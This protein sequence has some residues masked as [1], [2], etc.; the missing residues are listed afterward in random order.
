[1]GELAA[2]LGVTPVP[3]GGW[4]RRAVLVAPGVRARAEDVERIR[5]VAGAEVRANGLLAVEVAVPGDLVVEVLG[6]PEGIR[7]EAGGAGWVDHPRTWENPGFVVRYA[8]ARAAAVARWAAALGVPVAT[9]EGSEGFQGELLDRAV[10]RR[11]LR[12]LA[13]VFSRREKGEVGPAYLER[14]AGVYHDA[15][16]GAAA[17]PRGDEAVSGVHVARVR[18]AAAVRWVLGEGM[19]GLGVVPP[20]RI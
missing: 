7:G 15:F 3:Q 5:G 11:V 17:V 13:E 9:A 14:L 4:E 10:E 16:E 12:V 8:Y 1:M 6:L 18:M 19:R 20:E 2:L